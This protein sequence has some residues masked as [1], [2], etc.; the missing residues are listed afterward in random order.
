MDLTAEFA[1]IAM[2]YGAVTRRREYFDR[3]TA[4]LQCALPQVENNETV[5]DSISAATAEFGDVF[6]HLA[7]KWASGARLASAKR[8][9]IELEIDGPSASA[10]PGA[11]RI[12]FAGMRGS[13]YRLQVNGRRFS[14]SRE[15]ME[16]GI[17]LR[18]NQETPRHE[19]APA[20]Q[21]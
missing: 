11:L 4:A 18:V 8:G 7:G 9:L 17:H 16:R 19:R 20:L 10:S 2:R 21:G 3:G 12:V 13:N 5:R 15:E 1:I 14:A 6:V